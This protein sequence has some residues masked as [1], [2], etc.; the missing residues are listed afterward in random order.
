M[1][2]VYDSIDVGTV[3]TYRDFYYEKIVEKAHTI[4]TRD[5]ERKFKANARMLDFPG[6]LA[7]FVRFCEVEPCHLCNDP[8]TIKPCSACKNYFEG[9]GN[10]ELC[11]EC[12]GIC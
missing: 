8:V 4:T 3:F 2:F 11:H 9:Y 10:Q 12:A 1:K 7:F 5:G 6:G